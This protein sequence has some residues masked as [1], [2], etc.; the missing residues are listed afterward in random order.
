MLY[1][2]GPSI[3]GSFSSLVMPI[4]RATCHSCAF[5]GISPRAPS[6]ICRIRPRYVMKIFRLSVT[7]DDLSVVQ[8]LT[9]VMTTMLGLCM[10]IHQSCAMGL[11]PNEG[12]FPGPSIDASDAFYI[13]NPSGE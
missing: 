10:H 5:T 3:V 6:T 8:T 7:L 1:K 4:G 11:D 2:V 13:L 9:Q 12:D